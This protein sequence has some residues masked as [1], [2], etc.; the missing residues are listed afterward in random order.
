MAPTDRSMPPGHQDERP[1]GGD[2]ERR[3]LL[4][5]DVEQVD[6]GEERPAGHRQHDEQHEERVAGSRRGAARS[7]TAADGRSDR[8]GTAGPTTATTSCWSIM[9]TPF[10][11][12]IRGAEGRRENRR[13]GHGLTA[14]LGDDPAGAHHQHP[15]RKPDDLLGVGGDQQHAEAVGRERGQQFVDGAL[16]A[17]VD[18]PGRLVGDQDPR[19]AQQDAREQ[20]L[21]L[22]AAGQR[23]DRRPLRRRPGRRPGRAPWRRPGARPG[24]RRRPSSAE[25]GQAGQARRSPRSG[26]RA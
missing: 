19:T 10:C 3:G 18:A 23:A 8:Q 11:A 1:G 9:R 20:R 26:A 15:V 16:G 13:F 6:P 2:D 4:V 21:L 22:I 25:P 24:G 7:A 12:C 5:E 14:E 17:D